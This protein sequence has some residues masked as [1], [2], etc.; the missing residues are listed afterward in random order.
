MRH[1]PPRSPENDDLFDRG[2]G[3]APTQRFYALVN[4]FQVFHFLLLTFDS[5]TNCDTISEYE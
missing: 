3:A 5:F 4:L 1:A 2:E